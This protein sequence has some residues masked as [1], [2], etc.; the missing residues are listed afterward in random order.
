M[1]QI[2]TRKQAQAQIEEA[3][4]YT[5]T[6]GDPKN[7]CM[8]AGICHLDELAPNGFIP[9]QANMVL[10]HG[11]NLNGHLEL[12]FLRRTIPQYYQEQLFDDYFVVNSSFKKRQKELGIVRIKPAKYKIT[13]SHKIYYVS[14][15]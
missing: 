7:G 8:G 4:I 11:R 15:R 5:V 9:Q 6:L 14:F 12:G 10:A 1:D 3:P 2:P 13:K